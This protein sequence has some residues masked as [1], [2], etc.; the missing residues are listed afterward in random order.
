MVRMQLASVRVHS[1]NFIPDDHDAWRARHHSNP[2]W[3]IVL[4]KGGDLRFRRDKTELLLQ[5]G[6]ML[7]LHPNE[8]HSAWGDAPT[9]SGFYYAQFTPARAIPTANEP[10]KP[11]ST[12]QTEV[13]LPTYGQVEDP[14]VFDLFAELVTEMQ[15]RPPFYTAN[16]IALCIQLLVRLARHTVPLDND[17]RPLYVRSPRQAEIVSRLKKFLEFHFRNKLSSGAI[18]YH[19]GYDYA[20]LSRVFKQATHMTIT[21]YIHHL[22]IEEARVLLLELSEHQSIRA[23]AEHV[24]FTDASYFNRVFRRVV[25]VSPS[26]YVRNAYGHVRDTRKRR[27]TEV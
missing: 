16:S 13:E 19:L 8:V 27:E 26:D 7:T 20:Y 3:Q 12:I 25:G 24:G 1:A 11:P 18:S 4:V 14:K 5:H 17:S 22:R 10:T 2:H 21:D 9:P 6:Q 23:V 15:E